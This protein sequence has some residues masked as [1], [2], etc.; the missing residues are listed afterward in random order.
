MPSGMNQIGG[1]DASVPT[2]LEKQ[3]YYYG[4]FDSF[5]GVKYKVSP[6][7]KELIIHLFP[8]TGLN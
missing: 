3:M 4:Q 2:A 5:V 1:Y 8:P 7:T 6:S